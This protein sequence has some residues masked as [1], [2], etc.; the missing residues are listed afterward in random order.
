MIYLSVHPVEVLHIISL[1]ADSAHEDE[2]QDKTVDVAE[3]EISLGWMSWT[4]LNI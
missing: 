3:K 4:L 2:A 1:D